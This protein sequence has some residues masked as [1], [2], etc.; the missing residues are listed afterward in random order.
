M[1]EDDKLWPVPDRIGRQVSSDGFILIDLFSV[2]I[3]IDMFLG[4]RD[5]DGRPA[6]LLHNLQDRKS[7][8]LQ[9]LK[10]STKRHSMYISISMWGHSFQCPV[11]YLVH[12]YLFYPSLLSR[13]F[14]V[15]LS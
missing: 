5:S 2:V 12:D 9:K 1:Q 6:Y 15:S 14:A 11:N 13:A 3:C 4:T 10:V 8:G 7:T